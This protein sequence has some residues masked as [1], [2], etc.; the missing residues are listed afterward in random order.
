MT[1]PVA[2][3]TDLEVTYG[4]GAPAVRG[5]SLEVAPG[6]VVALVGESGSG[7]STTA[8]TLLGLLPRSGRI[9]AGSVEVGGTDVTRA[10]E[11]VLRSVRG[12]VVGLV[13]QDPMVGL[14]PTRRIGAQIAEAVRLRGVPRPAVAAEVL[15]A[16]EQAGVDD[17]GLRARQYPH[18]LSGGL[19]Q[20]AL[21]ALA[22]AGKPRLLVADEPTSALDVTVQRTILDHLEHLVRAQNQ[23]RIALLVITHDLAVAAD[24]ADRV[25]VMQDGRVVEQGRPADVLVDP[26]EA[27]TRRLIAAA[28]G[29]GTGGRVVPRFTDPDPARPVLRL[30][31]ATVEFPLPGRAP[32]RALDDVD[33]TVPAGQTLAVVGESGSGKTTAL[34]VA[35]GL[36]PVTAGRVLLDEEDL[37]A[38]SWRR[39]RPVRRRVQL[40]HQNPFAALDP[41]FTVLESVV[42]PL[43]SFR[44]GDRASRLARARE[45]LDRVGLPASYL[46]R[47]P[48]E[49]SGGQRQ[50]VAIARALALDPELLLL[51]EPVSAL[52]VSV[53][54]Q[55]LD[56]LVELQQDLGVSY[57]FVSH[58]LAVVA[59]VSHHVAV[60]RRGRVVE[61]GPTAEVFADPQA[62]YTRALLDAI[63]GGRHAGAV[64]S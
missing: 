11:R 43:V 19:R 25:L 38:A 28:P 29:L 12:G 22:L 3:V 21:I 15:E 62:Q 5:V 10:G 54:A 49:L 14:N 53:Q 26:Q 34:R 23:Q 20:R 58:D 41:R 32:L 51:D 33:L 60:L 9:T 31:G 45:L 8:H 2:R 39:W 4:R 63:P 59:Q 50:R 36:Q 44:V 13:P 48:A 37:T 40:V 6:E 30:E 42:E 46:A 17:P 27:Y 24:R 52:D 16:L 7:K 61:H 56:L 1:A 55:I 64:P 18:E 47:L 57:L 35:L